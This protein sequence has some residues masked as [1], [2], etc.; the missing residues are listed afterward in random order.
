M[1]NTTLSREKYLYFQRATKLVAYMQLTLEAMDE[2]ANTPLYKQSMK[3]RMRTL[4]KE[5]E[6][7]IKGSLKRLHADEMG[8]DLFNGIQVKIETIM[9]LTLEEIASLREAVEEHRNK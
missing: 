3:N 6:A 4:E 2:F 8:S 1:S 9:D 5:L 7:A